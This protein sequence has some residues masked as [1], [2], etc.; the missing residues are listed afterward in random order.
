MRIDA[1][2]QFKGEQKQ[3]TITGPLAVTPTELTLEGSA[4][5]TTD[6]GSTLLPFSY[7]VT[8][9]TGNVHVNVNMGTVENVT[10]PV[11]KAV[12]VYVVGFDVA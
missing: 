3:F 10:N 12:N 2:Y 6:D 5:R 1:A 11:V 8:V 4:L 9:T 7:D